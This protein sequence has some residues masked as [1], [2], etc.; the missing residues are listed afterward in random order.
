M[1]DAAHSCPASAPY[2][3]IKKTLLPEEAGHGSARRPE[4]R[5]RGRHKGRT[6]LIQ[7][8]ANFF[9]VLE[10]EFVESKEISYDGLKIFSRC[11]NI[12]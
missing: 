6:A 1:T 4:E 5:P 10:S 12:G 8:I 7:R 2:K 11:Y 3:C 9:H